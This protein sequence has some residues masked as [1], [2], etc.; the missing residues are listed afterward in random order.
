MSNLMG[1]KIMSLFKTAITEYHEL[2][3]LWIAD[4]VSSSLGTGKS[5]IE[6]AVVRGT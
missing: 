6:A 4:T 2:G 1:K 5:I 3:G